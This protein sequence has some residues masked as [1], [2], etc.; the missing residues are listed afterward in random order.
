MADINESSFRIVSKR[1]DP[2]VSFKSTDLSLI[3]Q[4]GCWLITLMVL[5]SRDS[6]LCKA[7]KG[8]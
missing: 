2:A 1:Y 6:V 3:L 5:T 8:P 4:I 7:V